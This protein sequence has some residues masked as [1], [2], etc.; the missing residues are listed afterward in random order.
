MAL[1]A[2]QEAEQLRDQ[3]CLE[4]TKARDAWLALQ[5]EFNGVV[6]A[7]LEGTS[8]SNIDDYLSAKKK[9]SDTC[10]NITH[11]D[12]QLADE[13]GVD[14]FAVA[15]LNKL[16]EKRDEGRDGWSNDCAVDEL[17][18]LLQIQ[19]NKRPLSYLHIANFCMM[20]WNR[21]NPKG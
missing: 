3:W 18:V 7:V 15:M 4:Y 1:N 16:A 21:E 9:M 13:T 5:R 2:Q 14:R 12:G 8:F 11:I 20:I 6:D 17:K 19:L 10:G